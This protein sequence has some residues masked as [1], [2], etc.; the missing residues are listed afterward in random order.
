MKIGG[1][2]KGHLGEIVGCVEVLQEIVENSIG[3]VYEER[4]RVI[5]LRIEENLFGD[6]EKKDA[7]ELGVC[8]HG[9][10]TLR[11]QELLLIHS[12]GLKAGMI[13]IRLFWELRS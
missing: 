4:N 9:H 11:F 13:R 8:F 10:R 2:G 3:R 12:G 1:K 6:D 5:D 7:M